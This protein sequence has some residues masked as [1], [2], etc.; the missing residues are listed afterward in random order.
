MGPEP[1]RI[2]KHSGCLGS[3]R[4]FATL[5]PA[6]MRDLERKLIFSRHN[7]GS[8]LYRQGEKA[9]SIFFVL[10]GRI[11]MSAIAVGAKTALLKIASPGEVLGLAEVLAGKWHLTT[12]QRIC[13]LVYRG[14]TPR[15]LRK[16]DAELSPALRSRCSS[17]CDGPAP[18]NARLRFDLY[19]R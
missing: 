15:P 17:S 2:I 4:L 11:K 16:C 8:V 13:S 10:E 18:C 19:A 7:T 14:F 1:S 5:S 6:V 9:D 12:A 3:Q